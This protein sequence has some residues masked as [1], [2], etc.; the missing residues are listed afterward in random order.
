MRAKRFKSLSLQTVFGKTTYVQILYINH[1]LMFLI[2]L[3][4]YSHLRKVN[5][6]TKETSV[7]LKKF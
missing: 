7:C 1:F 2:D 4:L 3:I 6:F 5:Y